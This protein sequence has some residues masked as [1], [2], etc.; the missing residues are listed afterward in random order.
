MQVLAS[1]FDFVTNF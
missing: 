1:A